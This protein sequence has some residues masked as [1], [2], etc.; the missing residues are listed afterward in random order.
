MDGVLVAPPLA[1]SYQVSVKGVIA[2]ELRF[3][4]GAVRLSLWLQ[5]LV[6]RLNARRA[7]RVHATSRYAAER[8]GRGYGLPARRLRVV[9]EPI[10]LAAWEAAL[11]AAP[12]RRLTSDP[13]RLLSVAH[14]YP[15]KSLDTLVDALALVQSPIQAQVVGVGPCLD[16]WRLRAERR[17]LA[18][19]VRFLG[20]VPFAQLV[21]EYRACDV[22]CLPSRQEGFGIVFLEA[23]AAGRP[24]LACAAAAVPEVVPDGV[25]GL[26]VPPADAVALAEALDR[27]AEDPSL[28]VRLA[29]GGRE[30]V[31]Q[32]DAD[33]VARAFL[34]AVAG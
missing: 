16:A 9:P 2:E 18:D 15:R 10:D 14:L 31:R 4:R 23:M 3:E 6:E 17:G 33:R 32:F 19:R 29:D 22:F 1:A 27:L 28:R 5:S 12:A 7:A 26:L 34:D 13:L 20:H 11:G 21:A 30:H 8:I 24:V 25:A